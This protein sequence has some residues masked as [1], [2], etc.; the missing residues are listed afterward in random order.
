ME[1]HCRRIGPA[2][3]R[4]GPRPGVPELFFSLGRTPLQSASLCSVLWSKNIRLKTNAYPAA[5]SQTPTRPCI[6]WTFVSHA[7]TSSLHTPR[8]CRRLQA[9]AADRIHLARV[10]DL[11]PALRVREYRSG[12]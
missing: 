8:C 9:E 6:P 12:R 11:P 5:R 10:H 1:G 4:P 7:T 3:R 2:C